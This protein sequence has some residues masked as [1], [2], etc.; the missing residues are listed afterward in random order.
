MK[1]VT[2]STQCYRLFEGGRGVK[3]IPR[4]ALLLLKSEKAFLAIFFSDKDS[5]KK[6]RAITQLY[7]DL[8]HLKIHYDEKIFGKILY[9]MIKALKSL[10]NP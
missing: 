7:I 10:I 5:L 3:A 9:N 4:T 8:P 1:F 6:V 2:C